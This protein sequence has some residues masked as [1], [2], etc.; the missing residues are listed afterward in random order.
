[1][2]LKKYMNY[3]WD[4]GKKTAPASYATWK[5]EAKDQVLRPDELN[6]ETYESIHSSLV[7]AS[8]TKDTYLPNKNQKKKR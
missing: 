1:M 5:N 3:I 6:S 7:S 4:E 8:K 2:L